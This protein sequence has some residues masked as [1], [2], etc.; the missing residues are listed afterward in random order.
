MNQAVF[1]ELARR[2]GASAAR[3]NMRALPEKPSADPM[4]MAGKALFWVS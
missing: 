1:E 4:R 2:Q 3:Q